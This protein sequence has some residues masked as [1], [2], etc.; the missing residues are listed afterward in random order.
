MKYSS[1]IYSVNEILSSSSENEGKVE[2]CMESPRI[3]N[4]IEEEKQF[5]DVQPLRNED[6]YKQEEEPEDSQNSKDIETSEDE[7]D[8]PET[9][10]SKMSEIG[11]EEPQ[12]AGSEAFNSLFQKHDQNMDE[13]LANNSEREE[14]DV[15]E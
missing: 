13:L 9:T 11:T 1:L 7:D 10:P 4:Y 8:I 3:N 5:P 12:V 2:E 6:I 15:E 14:S